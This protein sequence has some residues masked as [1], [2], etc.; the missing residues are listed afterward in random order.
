[1]RRGLRP[2]VGRGHAGRG[3]EPVLRSDGWRHGCGAVGHRD[4]RRAAHVPELRE[5]VATLLVHRACDPVPTGDLLV[6]IHSRRTT[7]PATRHGNR[8]R[9]GEDASALRGAL[10]VLCE[11]Q[12]A[13]KIAGLFGP[14]TRQRC[15]HHPMCQSAGASLHWCAEPLCRCRHRLHLS[16]ACQ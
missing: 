1:M 12:V 11:H 6:G 2:A 4:V 7:P 10:R 3:S 5:H 9:L 13:R 14:R 16:L 15:H 8:R